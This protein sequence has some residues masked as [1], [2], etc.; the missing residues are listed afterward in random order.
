MPVAQ[1]GFLSGV[2][3]L[4]RSHLLPVPVVVLSCLYMIVCCTMMR[5]GIASE[6][7]GDMQRHLVIR[8]SA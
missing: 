7:G 6:S 4:I 2:K 1:P 5:T 3:R 8:K